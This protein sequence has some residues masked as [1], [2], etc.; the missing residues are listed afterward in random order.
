MENFNTL[1]TSDLAD[2]LNLTPRASDAVK[3]AK[4]ASEKTGDPNSD[5]DAPAVNSWSILNEFKKRNLEKLDEIYN[6]LTR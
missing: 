3:E 4:V 2:A 5:D 1:S 6:W